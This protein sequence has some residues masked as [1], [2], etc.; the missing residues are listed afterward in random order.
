MPI[1][2]LFISLFVNVGSHGA[3]SKDETEVPIL[4]WGA[5][6]KGPSRAEPWDPV[7]PQNWQLSGFKRHDVDQAD[8]VVLL[9]SLIGCS[10]PVNSV[11]S[12]K[13]R[14]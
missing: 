1:K 9:A 11:V 5:G 4:A 3:G 7:T 6:I 2:I 12:Y 13:A 8:I 14:S 10:I